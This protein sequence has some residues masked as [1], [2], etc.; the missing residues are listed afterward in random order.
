M[1]AV[2]EGEADFCEQVISYL[3]PDGTLGDSPWVLDPADPKGWR[4][5]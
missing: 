3:Y 1:K 2:A 5:F 4:L